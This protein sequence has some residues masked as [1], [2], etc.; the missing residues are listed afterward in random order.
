PISNFHRSFPG[1]V[2]KSQQQHRIS[3]HFHRSQVVLRCSQMKLHRIAKSTGL[4][5]VISSIFG[6]I[7]EDTFVPLGRFRMRLRSIS[8][9]NLSNA[10]TS[11]CQVLIKVKVLYI[12]L[13]CDYRRNEG[14]R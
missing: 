12:S 11:T 1:V 4:L 6:S 9:S 7:C 3:L 13:K 10:I 5:S 8:I 14:Q 2:C